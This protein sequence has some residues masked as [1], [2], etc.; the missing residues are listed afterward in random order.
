MLSFDK[1]MSRN[2]A[3]FEMFLR[4]LKCNPATV[5]QIKADALKVILFYICVLFVMYNIS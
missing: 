5:K 1:N 2:S 3:V 4:S